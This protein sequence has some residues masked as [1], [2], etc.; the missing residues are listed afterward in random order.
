MQYERWGDARRG[1]AG[2]RMVWRDRVRP[3]PYGAMWMAA[4]AGARRGVSL[5]RQ[6]ATTN[7]HRALAAAPIS[8]GRTIAV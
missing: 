8:D 1:P 4:R 5:A 3:E 2:C 6:I 7:W